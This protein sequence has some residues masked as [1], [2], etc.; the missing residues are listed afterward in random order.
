[1]SRLSSAIGLLSI[2]GFAG[3]AALQPPA[4]P[5][6]VKNAGFEA[7]YLSDSGDG[8]WQ[9]RVQ[10]WSG[11]RHGVMNPALAQFK[12]GGAPQ[13]RNSAFLSRGGS[14]M[15]QVLDRNLLPY[16]SYELQV[17]VGRRMESSFGPG[18][19]VL[20]LY[21]GNQLLASKPGQTPPAGE[22][23]VDVLR[24]DSPTLLS[25]P[26]APLRIQIRNSNA[27]MINFDGLRLYSWN[28]GEAYQPPPLQYQAIATTEGCVSK[29]E[30]AW[31]FPHVAHPHRF[32][33]FTGLAGAATVSE[34][35][36]LSAVYEL[37]VV[38]DKWLFE[39]GFNC[40]NLLG[41]HPLNRRTPATLQ[42]NT[43]DDELRYVVLPHNAGNGSR[44]ELWANGRQ[45]HSAEISGATA[46]IDR[47]VTLPTGTKQVTLYH[48][49]TGWQLEH[50][51][52]QYLGPADPE[53]LYEVPAM[54]S[55]GTNRESAPP[56]DAQQASATPV[57]PGASH[58]E[59]STT[60]ALSRFWHMRIEP[61]SADVP[62][63]P[64]IRAFWDK[65]VYVFFRDD[66]QIG[67][68]P[69]APAPYFY[70]GQKTWEI[71]ADKLRLNLDGMRYAL[72]LPAG[73][74]AT[75]P[76]TTVDENGGQFRMLLIPKH[77]GER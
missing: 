15:Y 9:F 75:T 35:A 71:T 10:H 51:F 30:S 38:D 61:I 1:M 54:S 40:R 58:P 50:L 72:P 57:Q 73:H 11:Q 56:V 28:R 76:V 39:K 48:Y 36:A 13:G 29:P 74:P 53:R 45:L 37:E 19:Y 77:E 69:E 20:E 43:I 63:D 46:W 18:E 47:S 52:W 26:A 22:F 3:C 21:A 2:L 33:E 14:T 5:M 59:S 68:N 7:D 12:S 42:V 62:V 49:A 25:Q 16:R 4:G 8:S 31:R 34:H 55:A 6:P 66:G 32:G 23:V 27:Q 65:G 67:F 60:T 17:L 70:Q 24:Y 44:I 64:G 41:T